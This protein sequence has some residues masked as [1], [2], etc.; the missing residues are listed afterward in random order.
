ME[1]STQTPG[2]SDVEAL[3]CERVVGFS[4]VKEMKLPQECS[5]LVF[6]YLVVKVG[7]L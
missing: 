5:W 4:R 7:V 2:D 3:Y 6:L 1:A